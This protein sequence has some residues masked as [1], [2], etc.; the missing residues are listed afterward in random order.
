MIHHGG[1]PFFVEKYGASASSI[2]NGETDRTVTAL[3]IHANS[4]HL[5]GNMASLALF[6]RSYAVFRDL[7][8][9]L[10]AY[11]P[12][13]PWPSRNRSSLRLRPLSIGASTAVFGA[14][15]ILIAN[16]TF[17]RFRASKQRFRA[18][19]PLGGG[20]CLLGLFSQG[21]HTDILAHLFGMGSGITIGC[22][23]NSILKKP[24]GT[25]VQRLFFC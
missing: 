1:I 12:Q 20:I 22:I 4:V 2:L 3:M 18:W 7:A 24:P 5:A 16:E 6:L 23:F 14:I 17:S 8:S 13:A 21:E 11:W 10:F 19:L 9:A 25:A 15:G